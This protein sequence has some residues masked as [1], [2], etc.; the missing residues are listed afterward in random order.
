MIL[1]WQPR[2]VQLGLFSRKRLVP[3]PHWI[4]LLPN[5]YWGLVIK[6]KSIRYEY[7]CDFSLKRV[8]IMLCYVNKIHQTCGD[9]I[10]N[11]IWYSCWVFLNLITYIFSLSLWS[12]NLYVISYSSLNNQGSYIKL[13]NLM[14]VHELQES[15]DNQNI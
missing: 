5:N 13:I 8:G 7:H 11:G 1:P 6:R 4:M 2:Q 15:A 9:I 10:S 14:C 3:M 12:F